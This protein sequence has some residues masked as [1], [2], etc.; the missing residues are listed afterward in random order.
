MK[1]KSGFYKAN[2]AFFNIHNKYTSDYATYIYFDIF[3]F[4]L[5]FRFIPKLKKSS[6]DRRWFLITKHKYDSMFKK[7][8]T[9]WKYKT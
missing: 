1:S 6:K 2:N 3:G 5:R 8:T 9:K 7:G 4:D